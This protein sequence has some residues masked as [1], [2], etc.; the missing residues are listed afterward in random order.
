MDPIIYFEEDVLN[1]SLEDFYKQNIKTLLDSKVINEN[2]IINIQFKVSSA[3][4][5]RSIS[6]MQRI[7]IKDFN[8]LNDI[9]IEFWNSTEGEWYTQNQLDNIIYFYKIIP[10][11]PVAGAAAIKPKVIRFENSKLNKIKTYTHKISNIKVPMTMDLD[12]W[13]EV[14]YDS[15]TNLAIVQN[16]TLI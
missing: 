8:K 12:L 7:Y 6:L 3:N 9:F 13:G 1:P 15:E 14:V 2:D 16:L 11:H 4:V 10:N 5:Y